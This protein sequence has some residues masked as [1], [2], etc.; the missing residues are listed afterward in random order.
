MWF[1]ALRR[2]VAPR[3]QWTVSV[4]EHLAWMQV[5]HERG[6]IVASGPSRDRS[7]GIYLIRADSRETAEVIAASD[8]LTAAGHC[9]FELI[10]WDIHQ[11]VGVG[12]FTASA[13]SSS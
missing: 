8:P 4:D 5:Q 10:E 13:L 11:I 12:P 3:D 2:S 7:L 9:T 6:A 1:L